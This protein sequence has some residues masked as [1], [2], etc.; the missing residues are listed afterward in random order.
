MII[1]IR[2]NLY[3]IFRPNSYLVIFFFLLF[4]LLILARGSNVAQRPSQYDAMWLEL[5]PS[6][7]HITFLVWADAEA[8]VLLAENYDNRDIAYE[9]GL[10][11]A[12][13]WM[14]NGKYHKVNFCFEN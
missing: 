6:A 8:Y 12:G 10:G 4:Y 14:R 7:T 2:R 9:I 3:I 1:N 11:T 5:K 13:K